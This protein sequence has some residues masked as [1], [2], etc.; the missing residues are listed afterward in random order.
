M[1]DRQP[2]P[3]R[4]A[5]QLD[6]L[7]WALCHVAVLGILQYCDQRFMRAVGRM[8]RA[9]T[10]QVSSLALLDFVALLSIFVGLAAL[11]GLTVKGV[12]TSGYWDVLR[13]MGLFIVGQYVAILALNPL[14]LNVTLTTPAAPG[15]EALG[16][17]WF[18]LRCLAK[19][20]PVL[21]GLG[22]TWG[23]IRLV[24]AVSIYWSRRRHRAGPGRP[25]STSPWRKPCGRRG[26]PSRP[27]NCCGSCPPR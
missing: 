24:F 2:G 5:G 25:T 16:I 17:G 1:A 19:T 10:A 18:L 23:V 6:P 11:I 8:Q 7:L 4:P 27:T 26:T 21:Y 22:V 14:S 12:Q 15:C 9:V 13:A 3:G 20:V